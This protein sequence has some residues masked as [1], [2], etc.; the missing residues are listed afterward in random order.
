MW[1]DVVEWKSKAICESFRRL[2]HAE[3]VVGTVRPKPHDSLKK[4]GSGSRWCGRAADHLEGGSRAGEWRHTWHQA[5]RAS[6]GLAVAFGS[7]EGVSWSQKF[8]CGK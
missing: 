8:I 6:K 1:T 2:V 7:G 5:L 4:S 3:R